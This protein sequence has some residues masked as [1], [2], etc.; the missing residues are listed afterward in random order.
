MWEHGWLYV[1]IADL[2]AEFQEPRALVLCYRELEFLVTPGVMLF[3][4]LEIHEL[5]LA[6][7]GEKL[8]ILKLRIIIKFRGDPWL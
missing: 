6:H 4:G 8:S 2:R 1:R 7:L 5:L 3:Q